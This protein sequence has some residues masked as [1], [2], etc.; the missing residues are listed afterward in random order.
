MS[1]CTLFKDILLLLLHSTALDTDR[2]YVRSRTHVVVAAAPAYAT[3]AAVAAIV[4][5]G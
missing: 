3:A 4:V 2:F 5:G 1:F